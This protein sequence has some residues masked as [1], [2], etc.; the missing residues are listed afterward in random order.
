MFF[1]EFDQI[2]YWSFW[3]ALGA[4][5]FGFWMVVFRTPSLGLSTSVTTTRIV[6]TNGGTSE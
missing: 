5:I 6:S 1:F 3:A 2:M 4:M